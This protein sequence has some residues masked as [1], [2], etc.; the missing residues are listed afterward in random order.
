LEVRLKLFFT[1][2][3]IEE[4]PAVVFTHSTPRCLQKSAVD[5]SCTLECSDDLS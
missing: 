2:N 5:R 4:F 1:A 3:E